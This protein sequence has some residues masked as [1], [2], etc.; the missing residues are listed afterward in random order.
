M[1]ARS[2][3]YA[4]RMSSPASQTNHTAPSGGSLPA[5]GFM[6]LAT[7]TFTVMHAAIKYLSTEP[8]AGAEPLHPMVIAFFRVAFGMIV[9]VPFILRDGWGLFQTKRFGMLGLRAVLNACAM[10]MFFT[11]LSLTTLTAATALG[12][13]APIFATI[14]AM[15]LLREKVG[16]RRWTAILVGFAGTMVVL[17]P[18]VGSVG[19]GDLLVLASALLWG[20]VMIVVKDLGRTESSVT[21]TAYMQLM[22]APLILIAAV[23]VWSWPSLEQLFALVLIGALGGSAQ[24]ALAQALKLS[25]THVIMPFEF[26][27]LIW[28]GA[29]S[30]IVFAQ[31]PDLGTWIGGAIIFAAGIYIADRER[32][33]ARAAGRTRPTD[34]T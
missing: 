30:A 8:V 12:F 28:A 10:V 34:T 23:F 17:R 19:V 4:G 13:T 22:M 21:I 2:E 33:T 29:L 7:L 5:I 1:Q 18:A 31:L 20:L 6:L 27:R 9:I 11:A 32:K 3:C 24:M 15:V 25:A 14:L 16:W 26:T